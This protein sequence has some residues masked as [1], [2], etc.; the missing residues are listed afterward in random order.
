MP[1]L[2]LGELEVPVNRIGICGE[3]IAKRSPCAAGRAREPPPAGPCAVSAEYCVTLCDLGVFVDQA[4]EPVP[5]QNPDTRACGGRTL[6]SGGRV[7]V[8]RPVRP[9]SVVMVGILA[10]DQ[11]QVPSAG[12][13]HPVQ[14]LAAGT[15]DPAFGYSI[16]AR[17]L[18]RSPH[19]P[20]ADRG[21]HGVEGSY[22]TLRALKT[23]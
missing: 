16:R 9:M 6:A 15:G 5:P 11:L 22:G 8:Q 21:E 10:E 7:L 12:D 4:A 17:R 13:Q 14:A 18:D 2:H 19:D 3:Q 23:G 20:H 1:R